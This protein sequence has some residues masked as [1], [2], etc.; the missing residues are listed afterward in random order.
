MDIEDYYYEDKVYPLKMKWFAIEQP[1]R[2]VKLRSEKQKWLDQNCL[3]AEKIDS[4]TE[5][6]QLNQRDFDYHF[7]SMPWFM[8]EDIIN[9]TKCETCGIVVPV[10]TDYVRDMGGTWCSI[11]CADHNTVTRWDC[12][13]DE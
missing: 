2:Y 1:Y 9:M 13:E 7:I 4:I 3:T 11:G 12:D 6:W 5:Y 10:G 8:R